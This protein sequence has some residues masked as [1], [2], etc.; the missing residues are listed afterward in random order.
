[1]AN[2]S[3]YI[4]SRN[5]NLKFKNYL[6]DFYIYQFK[7]V[8]EDYKIKLSKKTSDSRDDD[9]NANALIPKTTYYDDIARLRY[10]LSCEAG[11]EWTQGRNKWKQ[12]ITIDSRNIQINPFFKLYHLSNERSKA[13]GEHFVLI[14]N[15]LLY[16]H[17]GDKVL[18]SDYKPLDDHKMNLLIK[19]LNN[20]IE[21]I[22]AGTITKKPE[23]YK[24]ISINM[25]K[26]LAPKAINKFYKYHDD[27]DIARIYRHII[28][29][30]K[31]ITFYPNINNNQELVYKLENDD[32]SNIEFNQLFDA[33]E[34]EGGQL[35]TKQ[36]GN[37][38]NDLIK[39]GL[40][41]SKS[42][43]KCKFYSLS[44][45][46][47]KGLFNQDND[48]Y[49]RFCQCVSYFSEISVLGEIGEFILKRL[50]WEGR[51]VI[52]YKHHY[53]K[54]TLND[55][56]NIDILYA[57]KNDL[58]MYIEYRNSLRENMPYQT[59]LCYPLE[60]RENVTDGRQYLIYYYPKYRSVSAIRVEFIDNIKLGHYPQPKY[61]SEDI[62]N[63]RE[64]I[65]YTW[66]TSFYG[67]ADG[68]VK[69]PPEP[70]QLKMIVSYENESESFI[71]Q[72]LEKE[73]R[74]LI[75]CKTI[76]KKDYKTYLEITAKV[77]DPSELTKWLRS[78]FTR[79]VDIKIDYFTFDKIK[80]EA[81]EMYKLYNPYSDYYVE[82]SVPLNSHETLDDKLRVSL[83]PYKTLD[84]KLPDN[85]KEGN[86]HEMLF[87]EIY[88]SL[89]Q[90]M[91]ELLWKI[92]KKKDNDET[93]LEKYKKEFMN[94]FQFDEFGKANQKYVT[95]YAEQQ[96]QKIELFLDN[97]FIFKDECNS[98]YDLIPL[99]KIE[100]QWLYNIM[101]HPHAKYF[102]EEHEIS[103]IK[104]FVGDMN[105][106]DINDVVYRDSVFVLQHENQCINSDNVREILNAL[107]ECKK[108]KIK[109]KKKN[110]YTSDYY[111]SPAYLEYS[112][113]DNMMRIQTVG[114]KERVFTFNLDRIISVSKI[115]QHFERDETNKIIEKYKQDNEYSIDILFGNE[116]GIPDRILTEFSCYKK[117]CKKWGTDKYYMTLYYDRDDRKEILIRL[118]S[119]GSSIFILND[120]G[121]VRHE[122]IERLERQLELFKIREL[123]IS[124]D[125]VR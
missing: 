77:S 26:K 53:I 5:F 2:F 104:N 11:V 74:G 70:H 63:A 49:N 16:F 52:Y 124:K 12:C 29:Y 115:D 14:L 19:Y 99:L 32:S 116:K 59:I 10:V 101:N 79:I 47:I 71:K 91:A 117:L 89:F 21:D 78:Y 118:L 50:D 57:L 100:R 54:N 72:R 33:M 27:G 73:S 6:R 66:G 85:F 76:N 3:V 55:Y 84:D 94:Y 1:M 123:T 105:L 51:N 4:S 121:E 35:D 61:F 60:L 15:L 107:Y 86:L 41:E 98:F 69:S 113:K 58:W 92:I 8:Q 103:K 119:Y 93:E 34:Y 96:F 25:Q 7:E 46:F 111:V 109:Y 22:V 75:E 112:K 102:L 42:K 68:N 87:N 43:G 82:P 20:I 81:A 48:F 106:F 65:K 56:N 13:I 64:L 122:F 28:V 37:V 18:K 62:K 36:F 125:F 23:N 9:V 120:S 97:R 80:K 108:I 110:G 17:L 88:S 67:F 40:L 39:I 30:K 31:K 95:E 24:E 83:N 44:N 90:S 45:C 114:N 38:L